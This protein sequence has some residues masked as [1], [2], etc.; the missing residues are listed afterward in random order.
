MKRTTTT[1]SAYC[2]L[3]ISSTNPVFGVSLYE[4][5][6]LSIGKKHE[7]NGDYNKALN[8]YKK[9]QTENQHSQAVEDRINAISPLA[10]GKQKTKNSNS[11]SNS[12]SKGFSGVITSKS[13]GPVFV[14]QTMTGVASESGRRSAERQKEKLERL[15]LKCY[16]KH[17]Q[18]TYVRCNPSYNRNDLNEGLSILKR[19]GIGNFIVKDKD[20]SILSNGSFSVSGESDNSKSDEVSKQ[21][22]AEIIKEITETP[23]KI[24]EPV[25]EEK[26]IKEESVANPDSNKSEEV[27][28]SGQ[29]SLTS[30]P[31]PRKKLTGAS[32]F[33]LSEGYTALNSKQIP[34]AKE[35]F[36]DILQYEE[37]NVDASFGYALAFMNEGDWNKAY[38]TLSKVID[39]TNREDVK[40]T[41]KTIEY[42]MHLKEGWKNVS[43]APDKSIA[44]FLKAREIEPDALDTSEGLSYAYGNSKEFDKL[45]PEAQKLFA[46]RKDFKS[47]GM[48]IN[49]F[50]SAKLPDK[51]REFF[52]SLNPDF[53]VNLDYNP[54]RDEQ[55]AEAE[56][57]IA[58][59]RY[60]Q[61]KSVLR[62]LYLIYPTNSKVLLGFAKI[63]EAEKQYK[64]ALEY[65]ATVLTKDENNIDALSGLANVSIALEK[66]DDALG[67]L[68]KLKEQQAPGVE[69]KINETKL[70]LYLKQKNTKEALVLAKE[71]LADDPT[72]IELYLI[73]GD[74][75]VEMKKNRDAYFYYGRALQLNQNSFDIR[76]KLL[77]LLLEQNLFDQTQTLL[78]KF[79][80]F[81]MTDEEKIALRDFYIKFYK[82]YTATSLEEKDYAYALKGAQA[83][84]QMEPNDTFFIESAG[85]AALNSKKYNDVVYYFN[86]ILAKDPENYTIR[87]GVGL[88]YVN[89]KQMD[90]AKEYFRYAE[91]SSDPELLYKVAEIYRD[92]GL[93]KDSYR[94]V[95]L[96]EELGKRQITK[97]TKT[98]KGSPTAQSQLGL[99]PAGG[100]GSSSRDSMDTYN[101]FLGTTLSPSAESG[102][103]GG[104]TENLQSEPSDKNEIEVKKKIGQ[105]F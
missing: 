36:G 22:E 100:G 19:N 35:I 8:T 5:Q 105:W 78:E 71:M 75:N 40:N 69:K 61:A 50:L 52:D 38:I 53:Q 18:N 63:Y 79:K 24:E 3:L 48:L 68:A 31:A 72:N 11:N 58:D 73:L 23:K 77:N 84:L 64:S 83:G 15:G 34:K 14:I 67:Y 6:I 92:I 86:K 42:N 93:K 49:A 25:K 26:P 9:Y 66:Y 95:K 62:E 12:K 101:P 17:G 76:M 102:S 13:E 41:Y 4:E 30:R 37:N 88:A 57:L 56:S 70:K 32:K 85:W 44:H 7:K 96:I 81:Q 51:A 1:L 91:K 2:F 89:L 59:G 27:A 29:N 80:D 43:S 74:L 55:I 98:D 45:I 90:K 103:S 87:Y 10:N 46:K 94:V 65:Y 33:T 47:A 54:K 39:S 104:E 99:T 97:N 16:V 28:E 82:K 21:K 60:R 20:V